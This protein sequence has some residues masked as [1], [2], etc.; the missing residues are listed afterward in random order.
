MG[1]DCWS[2]E[3]A[4]LTNCC[5]ETIYQNYAS[6]MSLTHWQCNQI[7]LPRIWWQLTCASLSCSLAIGWSM[8]NLVFM[9]RHWSVTYILMNCFKYLSFHMNPTHLPVHLFPFKFSYSHVQFDK[10]ANPE[11]WKFWK[12]YENDIIPCPM[13]MF[14][15]MSEQCQCK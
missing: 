13:V 2:Q 1:Q 15:N 3:Q 10:N 11:M 9:W 12:N 6:S 8:I 4:L 5:H 14:Q 7:L